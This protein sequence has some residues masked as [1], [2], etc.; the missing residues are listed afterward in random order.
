VLITTENERVV[1]GVVETKAWEE[2]AM[3]V[4]ASRA[5]SSI[6]E[7]FIFIVVVVA[8]VVVSKICVE[9][10]KYVSCVEKAPRAGVEVYS[11]TEKIFIVGEHGIVNRIWTE[12]AQN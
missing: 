12:R 2:D 11:T 7:R 10:R 1:V 6:L 5:A 8:V 3:I 4:S 9:D